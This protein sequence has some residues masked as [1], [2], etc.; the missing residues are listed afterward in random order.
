MFKLHF[1]F[2]LKYIVDL[3]IYFRNIENNRLFKYRPMYIL[4]GL[5]LVCAIISTPIQI[6][7]IMKN[8]VTLYTT[9]KHW[10][11]RLR[12]VNNKPSIKN[13]LLW[14]LYSRILRWITLDIL[15]TYIT[16]SIDKVIA[17]KFFIESLLLFSYCNKNS[18]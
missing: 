7:T 13:N 15:W 12:Y 2:A 9:K 5:T 17:Y 1:H 8:T 6:F 3:F 18:I 10:P 4:N 11:I 14:I 16:L